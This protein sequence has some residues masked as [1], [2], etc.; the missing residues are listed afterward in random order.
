MATL[1]DSKALEPRDKLLQS[2]AEASNLL[3]RHAD[4]DD[5]IQAVLAALGSM[6][7]VDRIY[8]FQ[9]QEDPQNGQ[10][11]ASQRYAWSTGAVQPQIDNPRWQNVPYTLLGSRWYERLSSD[12][13]ISG[14]V[15][16]FPPDEQEILSS[17]SVLSIL[18]APIWC[19]DHFWGFMGFDNCHSEQVWSPGEQAMLRLVAAAIGAT[20][21]RR[22]TE[23]ESNR[24]RRKFERILNGLPVSIYEKDAQGRYTFVNE[25]M[26]RFLGRPVE[27]LLGKTVHDIFAPEV[28][29][30]FDRDDQRLRTGGVEKM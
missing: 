9:N 25:E 29:A 3:L 10:P 27:D 16:D 12:Q 4:L 13:M 21:A 26:A 15:R 17:P 18:V 23:A 6:P 19:G 2:V 28:A 7:A 8:I 11:C 30:R 14:L 24:Q 5:G 22:T 1:N 20:V